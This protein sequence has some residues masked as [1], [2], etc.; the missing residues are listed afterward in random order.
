M[1]RYM[2]KLLPA[3]VVA[4]A[5]L[6]P[7]AHAITISVAE[8]SGDVVVVEGSDAQKNAQM[9]WGGVYVTKAKGRGNFSFE[10]DLPAFCIPGSCVG[11]LTDGVETIA[12]ELTF[13]GGGGVLELELLG[14]QQHGPGGEMVRTVAFI[15]DG[16]IVSGGEDSHLRNWTSD[17]SQQLIARPVDNFIYDIDVS[18]DGYTLATGD[19]GWDGGNIFDTLR[20]WQAVGLQ[21]TGG[22]EPSTGYIYSLGISP[23]S[24]WTIATGFYPIFDVHPTSTLELYDTTDTKQQKRSKD[25]DFSPDGSL[26]STHS[27]NGIQIWSFPQGGC[28]PGDCQLTKLLTLTHKGSFSFSATF[29]PKTTPDYI[30]IVSG[31]D[32]HTTKLWTIEN[33]ATNPNNPL[34]S[35]LTVDSGSTYALA[36]TPDGT[37]IA[38]AGRDQITVYDST[39]MSILFQNMD[40]HADRMEDLA[41]SRDGS[42]IVSG[43]RD[44]ALKLW[45]LPPP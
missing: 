36:W 7:V 4:V 38:A 29:S 21:Q 39:D 6:A 43:A 1:T 3:G 2:T 27:S 19:G 11:M 28:S 37:R 44:G 26:V 8:V 25:M 30:Q 33:L 9:F 12:V 45:S 10:G 40:A 42:T 41:I 20:V 13:P 34:V 24:Q 31:T 22:I 23:D 17:L 16:T 14:V 15:A 18:A 32:K 5:L 35:V